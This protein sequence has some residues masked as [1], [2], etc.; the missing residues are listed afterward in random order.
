MGFEGLLDLALLDEFLIAVIY[1]KN[2]YFSKKNLKIAISNVL[3]RRHIFL[4]INSK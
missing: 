3:L 4:K 2:E 1:H